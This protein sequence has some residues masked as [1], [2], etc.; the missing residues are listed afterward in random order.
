MTVESALQNTS[1]ADNL[2]AADKMA[3]SFIGDVVGDVAKQDGRTTAAF[4]GGAL[5]LTVYP[6]TLLFSGDGLAYIMV[7]P[8]HAARHAAQRL[9]TALLSAL[10]SPAILLRTATSV[11]PWIVP[12][13]AAVHLVWF[14]SLSEAR[15]DDW[16]ARSHGRR[17][18]IWLGLALLSG[19]ALA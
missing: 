2:K 12:P 11:A 19:Y 16:L 10:S 6:A 4:L 7:T 9:G 5:M 15:R 1:A 13:A 18:L 3:R 8:F 14:Y 17:R